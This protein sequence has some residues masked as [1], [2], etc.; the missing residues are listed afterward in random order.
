MSERDIQVIAQ[1]LTMLNIMYTDEE[2]AY[3]RKL[4]EVLPPLIYKIVDTIDLQND[5]GFFDDI[6]VVIQVP[7]YHKEVAEAILKDYNPVL[8]IEDYGVEF[9]I[10]I[11]NIKGD[12]E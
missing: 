6:R 7:H 10:P 11:M 8:N 9:H 5:G 1:H 4:K 2:I 12:T 3:L